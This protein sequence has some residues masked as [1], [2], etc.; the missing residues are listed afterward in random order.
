MVLIIGI[1]SSVTYPHILGMYKR[2]HEA[3]VKSN[4]FTLQ[5]AAE[6]FASM[7]EGLYP[8]EPYLN[9][10]DILIATGNPYSVN[11][12]HI[13]D[14]CPATAATVSWSPETLLPGNCSY[15]NAFLIYGN[16]LAKSSIPPSHHPIAQNESGQGTVYWVPDTTSIEPATRGFRIYGDGY[17]NILPFV[18]SSG[19]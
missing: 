4:M 12:H 11:Y 16:C 9:V 17:N 8:V 3:S 14:V 5:V 18:I 13:A 6:N 1:L 7:A 19:F 15:K 10:C 2:S